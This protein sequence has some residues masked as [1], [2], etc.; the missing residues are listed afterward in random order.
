[1]VENN[2]TMTVIVTIAVAAST[3]RVVSGRRHQSDGLLEDVAPSEN[4]MDSRAH[5]DDHRSTGVV[6]G[7]RS[8]GRWG[9]HAVYPHILENNSVLV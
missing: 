3:D 4:P 2:T 9:D 7:Q 6:Q 8:L 5:G 1:M